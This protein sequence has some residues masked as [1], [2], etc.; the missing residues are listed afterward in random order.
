MNLRKTGFV[1]CFGLLYSSSSS[2]EEL[3]D[4]DDEPGITMAPSF[5]S[6]A[7]RLLPL[8][9]EGEDDKQGEE[10]I[11]GAEDE[12]YSIAGASVGGVDLKEPTTFSIEREPIRCICVCG[13]FGYVFDWVCALSHRK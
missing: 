1:V 10:L 6:F 9:E 2:E 12:L 3:R 5:F 4:E 7:R 13:Q 8:D 11:I